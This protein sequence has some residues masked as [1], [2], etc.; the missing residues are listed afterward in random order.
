[1]A[2]DLKKVGDTMDNKNNGMHSGLSIASL[3][4]SIIGFLTGWLGVGVFFDFLG[5]VLGIMAIIIARK[6]NTSCGIAIA[7]VVIGILG[8]GLMLLLKYL[9]VIWQYFHPQSPSE[10]P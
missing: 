10:L 1:M 7:G 9:P 2:A 4:L 5:I 6:Q 8:A 3:V